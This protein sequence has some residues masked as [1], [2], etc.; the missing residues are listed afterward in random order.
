MNK[1]TNGR[2]REVLGRDE[3]ALDEAAVARALAPD[4]A[5]WLEHGGPLPVS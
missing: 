4:A 1:G 3:I 2:W 5:Q